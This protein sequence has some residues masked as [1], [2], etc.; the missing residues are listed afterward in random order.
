MHGQHFSRSVEIKRRHQKGRGR[1]WIPDDI[2][3]SRSGYQTVALQPTANLQYR[4][5]GEGAFTDGVNPYLIMG[6]FYRVMVHSPELD[7]PATL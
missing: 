1:S 7:P 2:A 4:D 3:V 5:L 6:H